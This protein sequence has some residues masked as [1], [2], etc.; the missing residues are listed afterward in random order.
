MQSGPGVRDRRDAWAGD[1]AFVVA[2]GPR[3]DMRDPVT[4]S[5]R[6]AR[7]GAAVGGRRHMGIA[8]GRR[9]AGAP[10]GTAGDLDSMAIAPHQSRRGPRS[11]TG[12]AVTVSERA[13]GCEC[14]CVIMRPRAV[15][16]DGSPLVGP[17]LG[18]PRPWVVTGSVSLIFHTLECGENGDRER[19][20]F[21]P[22][23]LQSLDSGW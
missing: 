3:G 11:V 2:R 10:R 20:R 15:R 13:A 7:P 14:V 23:S 22:L 12:T 17:T 6:G 8:G 21:S 16:G 18:I 5:S 9:R 4:A 1:D 19:V